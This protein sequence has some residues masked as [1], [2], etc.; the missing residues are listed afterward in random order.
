MANKPN[1]QLEPQL[2]HAQKNLEKVLDEACA[3]DVKRVNTGELIRLEESLAMASK[4]AKE[5][6]SLRLRMRTNHEAG[7]QQTAAERSE[8]TVTGVTTARPHRVFEGRDGKE[9]HVFAI[10]PS[11]ASEH[12]ALPESFKAGWLSFESAGEVRRYAPLPERWTDLSV[13]QLRSLCERAESASKRPGAEQR[14]KPK[15]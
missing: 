1:E 14:P 3:P 4:A 2:R 9:W 11:P 10:H 6:V 7:E 5:V 13:E 15:N 8:G 12:V